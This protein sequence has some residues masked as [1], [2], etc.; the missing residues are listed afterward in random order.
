[1]IFSWIKKNLVMLIITFISIILV[2]ILVRLGINWITAIFIGAG[3]S[4]TQQLG[5][6]VGKIISNKERIIKDSDD[7]I[8]NLKREEKIISETINNMDLDGVIDGI[9]SNHGKRS[10]KDRA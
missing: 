8:E 10:G 3:I 1:M 9:K 4:G 2:I 5:K 7:E 6:K